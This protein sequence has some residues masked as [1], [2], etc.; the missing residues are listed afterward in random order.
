MKIDCYLDLGDFCSVNAGWRSHTFF[1]SFIEFLSV[2][3]SLDR[4]FKRGHQARFEWYTWCCIDNWELVSNILMY[5]KFLFS[6]LFSL[7][8]HGHCHCILV[9]LTIGLWVSS[10]DFEHGEDVSKVNKLC[11]LLFE[12]RM[13]FFFLADKFTWIP[14]PREDC[15]STLQW[16]Y[17]VTWSSFWEVQRHFYPSSSWEKCCR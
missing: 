1:M 2:L 15:Y 16:F 6:W 13:T 10:S 17:L 14:R 7:Q 5:C 8:F 3:L 11:M 4:I 9:D 12:C